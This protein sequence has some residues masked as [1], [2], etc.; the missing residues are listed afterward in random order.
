MFTAMANTIVGEKKMRFIFK[1][2]KLVIIASFND[3]CNFD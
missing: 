3:L 2:L 1:S